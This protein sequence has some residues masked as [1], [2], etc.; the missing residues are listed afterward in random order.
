MKR[1]IAIL[2]LLLTCV[3]YNL[4]CQTLLQSGINSLD[5]S[6]GCIIKGEPVDFL[7]CYQIDSLLQE[8][9]HWIRI[10]SI[11]GLPCG[12]S[13]S[14]SDPDLTFEPGDTACISF[15]GLTNDEDG[16]YCL[17]YYFTVKIT[18]NMSTEIYNHPSCSTFFFP[19]EAPCYYIHVKTSVHDTCK[20]I[21][22]Y[23]RLHEKGCTAIFTSDKSVKALTKNSGTKVYPNP[24][25][26]ELTIEL[27]TQEK[28]NLQIL[29]IQGEQI[30]SNELVPKEK[31]VIRPDIA[32]L[33]NGIYFIVIIS[34]KETW[35][36]KILRTQ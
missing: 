3:V 28:T 8:N 2:L 21:G 7:E 19:Q 15:S 31:L 1:A 36:Q 26:N 10:D 5:D 17:C 16:L 14:I 23:S 6:L 29:N 35:F 18:T 11:K 32:D 9:V 24:F 25:S 22:N 12:L 4:T 30:Y 20:D 13:Y 27:E 33:P 34:E